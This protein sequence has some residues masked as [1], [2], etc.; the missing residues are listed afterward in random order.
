MGIIKAHRMTWTGE[1][2]IV[3]TQT[4]TIRIAQSYSDLW[5]YVQSY[6]DLWLYVQIFK[7]GW[8]I[9]KWQVH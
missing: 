4:Q 2:I 6:G 5:L 9:L 8:A 3:I 1:A 7:I